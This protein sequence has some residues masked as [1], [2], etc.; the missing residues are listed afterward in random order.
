MIRNGRL[1]LPLITEEN[2]KKIF[3]PAAFY[4]YFSY[5][6]TGSYAFFAPWHPPHTAIDAAVP[7]LPGTIWIYLSHIALLFTAWWWMIRGEA[8][9]RAFWAMVMCAVLSTVYFFFF[10]TELPRRALADIDAGP[11]TQAAWAFLQQ[12]DHPTNSFPS[13]H[14][15]EAVIGMVALVRSHPHWGWLAPVWAGAIAIST[16]T[17]E[18]HVLV[19]VLGGLALATFCLLV[20]ERYTDV[21]SGPAATPPAG[22]PAT[23]R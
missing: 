20:S 13:M 11:V 4:L 9:T 1:V 21:V 22:E 3:W 12:A 6:L 16:L 18:Q 2:R 8:C 23:D 14:V 10:P 7:F 17:T 15:A 19:D 5:T